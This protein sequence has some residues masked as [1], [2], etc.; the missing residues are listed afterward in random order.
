MND[1]IKEKII[2]DSSTNMDSNYLKQVL[3]NTKVIIFDN[4]IDPIQKKQI[5]TI[6]ESIKSMQHCEVLNAN[7]LE[8]EQLPELP[9]CRTLLVSDNKLNKLPKLPSIRKLIC[10]R[11]KLTLLPNLDKC[12][13]LFVENNKLKILPKL[14]VVKSLICRFN[15]LESLPELPECIKLV[16]SNNKLNG[17]PDLPKCKYLDCSYNNISRL[18]K[19]PIVD[20]LITK[21]N[22]NLKETPVQKRA[23][24]AIRRYT[25]DQDIILPT[26]I[27]G[28][29]QI[30]DH[31]KQNK[32]EI[33][34]HG[35]RK[36][37]N[38]L[39]TQNGGRHNNDVYFYK[40]KKYKHKLTMISQLS[41]L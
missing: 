5:K 32:K 1:G 31:L 2:I 6:I 22:P 33:K 14:P 23:F 41:L 17:L 30:N 25:A 26:Q 20:V 38:Y 8:L 13:R 15:Q 4:K 16:C 29:R 27:Q 10:S 40:Y 34:E 3:L 39:L 18:P 12:T 11:N 19:L 37:N 9:R 24:A 35:T 7:T 28:T 21:G 36:I